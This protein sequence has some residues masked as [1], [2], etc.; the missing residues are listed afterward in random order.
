MVMSSA[1]MVALG[2][3]PG[4]LDLPPE[5]DVTAVATAT[6]ERGV[7]VQ[8]TETLPPPVEVAPP[9]ALVVAPEGL[10]NCQEMSWYRQRA[11]LPARFDAIGYR[12]SRCTNRDDVRTSCCHGYW[13]LSIAV[14]LRDH[15]LADDYH[16]CG[17]W[18]YADVNSDTPADKL[19]QACAAKALFDTVGWS[20]WAATS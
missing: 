6:A 19:R 2:I 10:S 12:E 5:I 13:Q 20:A 11:G 17:V 18:S 7:A 8:V 16:R 3:V 14:H 1:A 15:R 4:W 9:P